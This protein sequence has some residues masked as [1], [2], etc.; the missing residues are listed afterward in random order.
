MFFASEAGVLL[1]GGD[2]LFVGN[3][4]GFVRLN[5]AMPRQVVKRGLEQIADAVKRH[6][7]KA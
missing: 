7:E 4:E 6:G 5:L 2:K 1:E 3:A